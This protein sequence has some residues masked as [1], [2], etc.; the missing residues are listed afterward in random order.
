MKWTGSSGW[1]EV[2]C[3][4]VEHGVFKCINALSGARPRRGVESDG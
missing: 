4:A 1:L 3:E 2:D